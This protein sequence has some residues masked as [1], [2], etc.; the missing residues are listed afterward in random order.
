MTASESKRSCRKGIQA[1]VDTAASGL[2]I[3]RALAEENG[4]QQGADDPPGT[5]HVDSVQ[6][7]PLE[8]R[9]CM[10]GVSDTPFAGKGDGFIGTDMFASYLIRI[11]PRAEK[12]TLGP[13]PPLTGPCPAIVRRLPRLRTSRPSIPSPI[14]A[15]ARD[16]RQ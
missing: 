13:L 3:T 6:I 4:L 7:G 12:L 14:P 8:F 5:V 1:D 10:V 9:D 15:G 11:D 16:A 2:F